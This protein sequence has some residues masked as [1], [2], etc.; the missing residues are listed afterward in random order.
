MQFSSSF[1]NRIAFTSISSKWF[2]AQLKYYTPWR[3]PIKGAFSKCDQIR[4]NLY[5]LQS[6]KSC[7][8]SMS[9]WLARYLLSCYHGKRN[10]QCCRNLVAGTVFF[11]LEKTNTRQPWQRTSYMDSISG[12][13]HRWKSDMQR[14][15]L[16][17]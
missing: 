5:F 14:G 1:N 17:V 8:I 15:K 7:K 10:I 3:L 4:R 9:L 13:I 11:S 2:S 12:C 16:N 6:V